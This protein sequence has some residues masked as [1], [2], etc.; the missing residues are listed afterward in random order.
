M[1]ANVKFKLSGTVYQMWGCYNDHQDTFY[2]E[3][4]QS[5]EGKVK[6]GGAPAPGVPLFPTPMQYLQYQ[7][8]NTVNT[9]E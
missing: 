4:S 3:K 1:R 2:G 5:Y 6:S 7:I 8:P 9:H